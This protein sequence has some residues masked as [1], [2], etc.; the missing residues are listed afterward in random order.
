MP[1]VSTVGSPEAAGLL[2]Q[3]APQAGQRPAGFA[4]LA[5][6]ILPSS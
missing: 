5:I 1:G 3:I 6:W 2:K 4:N